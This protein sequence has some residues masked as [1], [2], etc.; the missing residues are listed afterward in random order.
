MLYD[1]LAAYY[2]R[3]EATTKRLEMTDILV[4]LLKEAEVEEMGPIVYLTQGKLYP[5]FV[6]TELGL[7]D[8]LVLRA[9]ES[10]T[11]IDATQ[12]VDL[13]R[14]TGDLG[15]AAEAALQAR[16][17]GTGKKKQPKKA[18]RQMT[19]FG[20]GDDEAGEP[21]AAEPLSVL[22]VYRTFEEI[23]KTTGSGS[24][25]RKLLLLEKLLL[26]AGPASAR[27]I[28]RTVTGKLRLGVADMTILD[29]LAVA[30]A[31]KANR[32]DLERAY[33]VSSDLGRV[34]EAMK[35]KGLTGLKGIH[36]TVGVPL[37]AMLAERLP[38]A[39][40]ILDK[41]GGRVAVELKYDGLRVQAHIKG[42]GSDSVHFYSRRLED[43][44]GQFPDVARA[45]RK[46]F[47]GTEGV[48]EGEV[49][50]VDPDTG[51][52]RPF[53]EVSVRRGRKHDIE[54]TAAEVPVTIYLF[55]CLY[56]DGKDLTGAALP[57]RRAALESAFKVNDGVQFSRY[58]VVDTPQALMGFFDEAV[59]ENAEG[60][61]CKALGP[62]SVYRAGARGYQWIKYKR[63][64]SSELTDSLDLV[65]VG[66][67]AGRGRR[68]GWYGA[69]LM[70]AYN[71]QDDVFETVCKLGT[72][73]DDAMLA[74]MPEMFRRAQLD[75]V[76]P[77]VR[78]KMEADYWF[79]PVHVAEVLG[80]E[81]TL[82]P[83]HTAAWGKVREGAGLAVRFPR[84]LGRWRT[85]K[86]PE[87][88]TSTKELLDMYRMQAEK[89]NKGGGDGDDA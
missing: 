62:D 30:F 5:D 88:A 44:T 83:V 32:P 31:E 6:G 20:M 79:E 82:S 12:L 29:A 69:L 38:E 18:P 46:A 80:A 89:G 43:L 16:F 50:A 15:D 68:K 71:K 49:V 85:D 3:L 40:Q 73:F 75:H 48:V 59:A 63:D 81:L 25:E 65:V 76:H 41:L 57:E 58:K 86:K 23:A 61:M 8:K 54:E 2:G 9:L 51:E 55:D 45:L 37:R 60:I 77:R 10:T 21:M 53:Q 4:E 28:V 33:N 22:E 26:R 66:A 87:D 70:A 84:F 42:D 35:K 24:Q 14:Q 47:K 17:D 39:D 72:G 64:Y 13:H 52:M 7:A 1:R 67:L 56:L 11:G 74:Q 78:S 27:Y 34:A 19:L 36:L